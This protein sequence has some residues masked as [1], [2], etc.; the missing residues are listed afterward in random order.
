MQTPTNIS[1]KGESIYTATE[2]ALMLTSRPKYKYIVGLEL[3]ANKFS[4]YLNNTLFGPTYFSNND[5][6]DLN[7]TPVGSDFLDGKRDLQVQFKSKVLTDLTI[8]Y[9]IDKR[10][11][12]SFTVSNILNVYPKWDLVGLTQTGKD[13]IANQPI[14]VELLKG[15]LT[16]NNRYPYTTYDGS[17]FSQLG[18]TFLGQLIYKF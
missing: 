15:G 17:H 14:N 8:G 7:G 5:L 6:R 4:F 11:S 3:V 12:V 9:T 10:A 16:F 18:T 1:N 13:F 2:A